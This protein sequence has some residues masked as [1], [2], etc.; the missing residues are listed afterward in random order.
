LRLLLATTSRGKLSEQR[1]ALQGIESELL[2][3]EDF[4]GVPPPDETG[5][6]FLE[7][8]R[9]KALYY[10][11]Q[12]GVP[13]VAEDAGLEIDALE[14]RPGIESARFLGERT[15]YEE[16]NARI[17]E[18]LE[19]VPEGRRAARYVSAVALVQDGKVLFEHEGL[20][21]G[22]IAFEPRGRQG[23]GYDPIFFVPAPGKTMAELTPEEKNGVSHR[24][25]ALAAL[26]AFLE[27]LEG[28]RP[29][30]R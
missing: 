14:G 12:T 18:L 10:E 2:S 24:G 3:L 25:K 7:N 26:R 8:A 30:P 5:R 27:G 29:R 22:Q 4:Q 20:C 17:L 13:S 28:R 21:D 23:F 19:D 9:L 1:R 6:T 15:P 11:R 16:K